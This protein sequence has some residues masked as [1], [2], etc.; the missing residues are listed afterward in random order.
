M[1][2][3]KIQQKEENQDP[4]FKRKEPRFDLEIPLECIVRSEH[5]R[6]TCFWVTCSNI[7]RTGIYFVFASKAH[8]PY[9]KQDLLK[10]T[11]DL[12]SLLFPRP[13]HAMCQ[14]RHVNVSENEELG[15]G[16]VIQNVAPHEVEDFEETFAKMEKPTRKRHFY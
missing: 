7:S 11:L 6:H 14:V 8:L 1:D 2:K 13:I 15:I 12:R 16:C 5:S 9:K 3:Q 4:R 10:C